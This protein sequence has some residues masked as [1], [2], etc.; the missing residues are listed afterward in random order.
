LRNSLP[1]RIVTFFTLTF[2]FTA[3]PA[4]ADLSATSVTSLTSWEEDG[5]GNRAASQHLDLRADGTLAGFRL[6]FEGYGRVTALD[7]ETEPGDEESNRL[8]HLTLSVSDVNERGKLT[9]GRQFVPALTGPVMFD[10]IRFTAGGTALTISARW[11][12]SSDADEGFDEGQQ[13]LGAGLDYNIK[14]G[15]YLTLDYGRSYDEGLLT[16]LLAAEWTYSWHRHTRAYVLFNWDLMSQTL[17]ESLLGTRLFFS[18]YF[19]MILEISQNVQAFDSDSI[20]SVFA[21][22]SAHTRSFSLLFTPT[23]DTRYVWDYAIESYQGD[24]AGRRYGVSGHW[25]PGQSKISASLIQHKGYGGE[26]TEISA[27][28]STR[29]YGRLTLGTGGDFSRTKNSGEESVNSTLIHAGTKWDLTTN[30]ALTLRFEHVDDELTED[31]ALSGRISFEVE[32]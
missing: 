4:L 5:E 25:S 11:G 31:P 1:T 17:H 2:F 21:V 27:N 18:D 24:G 12:Y 28:I 14:R 30:S 7:E 26:L 22:D 32:L 13:L 20:Y 16:E 15:M 3:V 23:P 29:F 19:T 6:D 9:F 10:G 8:Y